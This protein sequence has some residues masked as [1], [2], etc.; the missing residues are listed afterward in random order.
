M[1]ATMHKLICKL[2]L[3][4]A[5]QFH[6]KQKGLIYFY[7]QKSILVWNYRLPRNFKIIY[8]EETDNSFIIYCEVYPNSKGELC[9][10]GDNLCSV[11]S[12]SYSLIDKVV[13]E[14]SSS[15]DA[16]LV[17]TTMKQPQIKKDFLACGQ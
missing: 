17:F 6:K 11:G 9:W 10:Y 3:F 14:P 7:P 2:Y 12:K 15:N 16:W 13:Y 5:L 8:M 1:L 4:L